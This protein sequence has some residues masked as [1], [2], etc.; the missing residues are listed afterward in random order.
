M[1]NSMEYCGIVTPFYGIHVHA[2]PAIGMPGSETALEELMCHIL[3]DFLE[4]G[5]ITQIADDVRWRRFT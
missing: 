1:K 3:G 4:A 2:Q 5:P